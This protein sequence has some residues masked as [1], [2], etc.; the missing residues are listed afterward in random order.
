[1]GGDCQLHLP[2]ALPAPAHTLPPS[3]SFLFA[4]PQGG[5]SA[6]CALSSDTPLA[7][8]LLPVELTKPSC[9]HTSF[10]FNL[11]TPRALKTASWSLMHQFVQRS[12][13]RITLT[14]NPSPRAGVS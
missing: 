10:S 2:S 5:V 4:P 6:S 12:G 8:C 3:Q 14:T 7:F 13:S 1:M 9:K 11:L